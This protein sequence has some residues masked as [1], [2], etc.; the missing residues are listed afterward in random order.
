MYNEEQKLQFL[1]TRTCKTYEQYRAFFNVIAD[2]ETLAQKDLADFTSDEL[3]KYLGGRSAAASSLK[4]LVSMVT[5]YQKWCVGCG[6]TQ[7]VSAK[8][9]APED[10]SNTAQFLVSSPRDLQERFD[11]TF[12]P[13]NEETI[14]C[15]LRLFGWCAFV[16]IPQDLVTKIQNEDV[17]I[18]ARVI[19]AGSEYYH[20]PPQAVISMRQCVE[21]PKFKI[22]LSNGKFI[23]R[24]RRDNQNVF[25]AIKT[26]CF[27]AEYL[28]HW[29]GTRNRSALTYARVQ[30]SGM[31]YRIYLGAPDRNKAAADFHDIAVHDVET[32]YQKS[33]IPRK[34]L[35]EVVERKYQRD[36]LQWYHTFYG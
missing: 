16:G 2:K 13:E 20:M 36:Y 5:Q 32:S 22:A 12:Y 35:I 15:L 11:Q 9:I 7:T 10:L 29:F 4:N 23:C 26:E 34:R 33:K 1:T 3:I 6:L 19:R 14:D 27:S 8:E 25:R 17:Q 28:G 24:K 18:D 30:T 21:F 31:F